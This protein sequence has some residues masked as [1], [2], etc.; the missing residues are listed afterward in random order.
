MKVRTRNSVYQVMSATG[1]FLVVKIENRDLEGSLSLSSVG[2]GDVSRGKQLVLSL[3]GPLFLMDEKGN[4]TLQTS[5][6]QGVE[7]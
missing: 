7:I 3:G 5:T 2:V 1:G 6:V 4:A